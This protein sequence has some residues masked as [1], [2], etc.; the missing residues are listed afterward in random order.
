MGKFYSDGFVI[1]WLLIIT[2]LISIVIFFLGLLYFKIS[3]NQLTF[4]FE[5]DNTYLT[6]LIGIVGVLTAFSVISIWSIFLTNVKEKKDELTELTSELK[7]FTIKELDE[8]R[9]KEMNEIKNSIEMLFITTPSI[10]VRLKRESLKI[11]ESSYKK[12]FTSSDELQYNVPL[13]IVSVLKE[14]EKKVNA[15]YL[16][17]L[18]RE[19]KVLVNKWENPAPSNTP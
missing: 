16:S 17:D 15:K 2:V 13:K 12:E 8:I 1:R 6:I 19:L 5:S 11:L 18:K 4:N 9:K 14:Y 10:P 7:K 3:R